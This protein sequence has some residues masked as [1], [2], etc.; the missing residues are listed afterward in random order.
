MEFAC[1]K[2]G[3]GCG[4]SSALGKC[5]GQPSVDL[6]KPD[7]LETLKMLMLVTIT[8]MNITHKSLN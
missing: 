3:R 2:V 7:H 1:R 5:A 4:R 8:P 6:A